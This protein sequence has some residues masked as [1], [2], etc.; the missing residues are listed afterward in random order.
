LKL[1][2][3]LAPAGTASTAPIQRAMRKLTPQ[4]WV[5]HPSCWITACNFGTGKRV[6]F[7]RDL[8]ADLAQAVAASCAVPGYFQPVLIGGGRFVDGG[9]H[10]PTNL[11]LLAGLPLDLVICLC[12]IPR[13]TSSRHP[14]GRFVAAVR[15]A[16]I[17]QVES[18][19]EALRRSGVQVVVLAPEGKECVP[20][21]LDFMDSRRSD[22]VLSVA[23]PSLR[24]RLRGPEF[25]S[26]VS[27]LALTA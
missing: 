25:R 17:R 10:S 15:Q 3:A 14:L 26:L 22:E 23:L 12:P 6:V 1:I 21:G 18:E 5:A 27:D 11:D 4:G 7:G 9:V 13:E 19:A 8:D 16:A 2:M 24:R 20:M